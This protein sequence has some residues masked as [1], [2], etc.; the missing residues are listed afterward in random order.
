MS[1]NIVKYLLP[2]NIRTASAIGTGNQIGLMSLIIY[3]TLKVN[4]HSILFP[5]CCFTS[6][7]S[8]N[9]QRFLFQSYIGI[10]KTLG[11]ILRDIV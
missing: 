2:R 1:Q 4:M 11:M 8:G 10:G 6:K 3:I 5:V 9:S 7:H